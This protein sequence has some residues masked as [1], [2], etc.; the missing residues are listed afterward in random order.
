MK[1][2]Q[3]VIFGVMAA[4]L[5]GGGYYYY[6]IYQPAQA[7]KRLPVAAHAVP[8][9]P[10]TVATVGQESVPVRITTI[11]TA[12]PVSTVSI[13]SR[14]D[15]QIFKAGFREGQLVHRGDLLFQ[16]DPRPYE[17]ALE[18]AQANLL[19]DKAQLQR[20]Q[21][22]L[23]RY[24]ELAK[25]NY[26]PQQQYEAARATAEG[27]EATV[28][29]DESLI[30]AA[31]L[32]LEYTQIRSPIDG[33]TGNLLINVGNLVKANDTNALV[34]INQTQPI[35][36][37]FSIPEANL[38]KVRKRMGESKLPVSVTI[39]GDSGPPIEGEVTFINN[40][41]DVST[42][43]IQLKATFANKDDR[44]V[45]GQFVN[46]ALTL[47]TL[48]QA[49]VVP[50]QAV[51][52]GQRGTYVFVVK[53]DETVEQRLVELGPTVDAMAVIT[54]GLAVGERVVTEGQLRL[55]PGAKVDVKNAA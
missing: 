12:Q 19:R 14:V 42:G 33:R 36:V 49:L 31:R 23:K 38:P 24:A 47:S 46:V 39:P 10:V 30:S 3:I 11:G 8:P 29:A 1:L 4:A 27:T 43:T 37:S 17:A 2:R 44:L 7:V 53:P 18:Q 26:A 50:S 21:L 45:P 5:G 9:A 6:K 54:K 16:I 34:V 28:R 55:F 25:K 41:V 15:G 32:N 51:Q 22:D 35:Y 48:S 13:K 52:S 40:Q 20:S